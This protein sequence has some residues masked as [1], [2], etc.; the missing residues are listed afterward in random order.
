MMEM[1]MSLRARIIL[2][3]L[4]CSTLAIACVGTPLYLGSQQIASEGADR[5]LSAL[6]GRAQ[7]VLQ[8][9]VQSAESF[10]AMVAGMPRVQ[11][12]VDKEDRKGLQR[13]FPKDFDAFSEATGIAQFQFHSPE[14][15]S[16]L[17]VH[18]PST[19]GDDLSSFRPIVVEANASRLPLA[20]LERGRSGLVIRAIHPI[21][22][23]GDHA[24]SV[25]VGL[26][27]DQSLLEQMI[28]GTDA[29]IE[30][31]LLPSDLFTDFED[32][33][34]SSTRLHAG[35]DGEAIIP[36]EDVPD[37][38]NQPRE[39]QKITLSEKSYMS[40][41][42]VLKD[43]AGRPVAMVHILLPRAP[44]QQI[45]S[46]IA[47][48]TGLAVLCA[49]IVGGALAWIIGH[50]LTSY[51][52]RVVQRMRVLAAG[53]TNLAFDDL[54]G[55]GRE[56]TELAT[57]LEAFRDSLVEAE[58]L[59]DADMI[60]QAEQGMV[61]TRLAE[62]LQEVAAGNLTIRLNDDLGQGYGQ[63]V[64]DFNTAVEQLSN[65]IS[66]IAFSSET[67]NTSASEIGR[68]AQDLSNRTENSAA[69]LEQTAAALQDITN[70][71]QESTRGARSA[72]N[73][74]KAAIDKAQAGNGV[75][76]AA[77][78]AIKE[79][80][81]S[82]EEIAQIIS[83]ID[84]IA[85]Q[86]NLLALNAGVEAARAGEAGSGFAVVAAEV[87]ALAARTA[88]SAQQIGGL[89]EQ[90]GDKVQ[91]GVSLVIRTGEALKDI[92]TAIDE[93]TG[94]VARIATLAEEQ[95]TSLGEI[96]VAVMQLD[97]D[98]QTNAGMFNQ[99]SA[100]SDSLTAEGKR[101]ALLVGRFQ[102]GET[103]APHARLLAAE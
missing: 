29:A 1:S 57:G 88:E 76:S 59:R 77:V 64:A 26:P 65:V 50:R 23:G 37:A 90:S 41:I 74:G 18:D 82:S 68:A 38:V 69:T 20:G 44:Y 13:Q 33:D 62:G 31:Y 36:L 81:R 80:E 58:Q 52:T 5:E 25:E 75:V 85:F 6:W 24:G 28:D 32:P 97:K 67:V 8:A 71:V 30:L 84:D 63:L 60:R 9:R 87:R 54:K 79:V 27:L 94:Q 51:L 43:F 17:R 12:A 55:H 95:E 103:Q 19:Y 45:E 35:Y 14:A 61:V 73:S 89:I 96:N 48:V 34:M 78:D 21:E 72:D 3:I 16:I 100:A 53:D 22:A 86:T 49:L 70:A 91:H 93:V 47:M 2:A 66:D 15:I 102:S 7:N 10:T 83:M 92:V 56:I 98:T 46:Q 99:T 42:H 40:D 101:L 4:F 11:R 39:P